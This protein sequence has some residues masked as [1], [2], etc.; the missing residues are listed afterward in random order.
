MLMRMKVFRGRG[1]AVAGLVGVASWAAQVLGAGLAEPI[2]TI[3]EVGPE[4]RGN[5]EA[6]RAWKELAAA[7][8]EALPELLAGMNGAN[9]LAQNWLTAAV[10]AVASRQLASG[11]TLPIGQ[12]GQFLFETRND[13]R[14]RR[15]AYDLI[16]QVDSASAARLLPGFINDPGNE[17]RREA[18]ETFIADGQKMLA[19]GNKAGATLLYQQALG[20]SRDAAQIDRVAGSLRELGQ[21]VDLIRQFGFLV[22]WQVIGPFDNTGRA[23]FEKIFPPEQVLDFKAAYEG[24]GAQ[25]AWKSLTSTNDHGLVDLNIPFGKLKEV[26]GY[27]ATSF[28]AD[29]ARPA[30]LRLGC[31]NGWKIWFNGQFLFGRDEY[32]RGAEIDQYR[33]P[34]QLRAGENV[35]L[36]KLCQNEQKEDWTVEWEFQLRVT[37]PL[38]TPIYSGPKPD[39]SKTAAN[40]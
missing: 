33:L 34:V 11:G 6:S 28:Y 26:T 22:D 39:T 40:F 36:V 19:A 13:A 17:L 4:G 38:G 1:M 9:A 35:I 12:L 32:H 21:K 29:N 14:G 7:K 16:A 23:G 37:D 5:A 18:V 20:A 30:E 25:A 27:A 3:R 24:K 15:L 8:A 10:E 2:N 31:K